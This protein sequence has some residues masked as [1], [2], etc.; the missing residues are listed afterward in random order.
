MIKLLVMVML[1][2][3]CNVFS[4]TKIAVIDSGTDMAHEMII[5]YA[6]VNPGEI[7]NN[8]RDEDRNGYQDDIY[9]WNFAEDNNEIIDYSYLGLLS[10]DIRKF[11][12]IQSKSFDGTITEEDKLWMK[13]MREDA[14]FIN[15]ISTYGNFMHGTHVAGIMVADAPVDVEIMAVKLIPTSIKKPGKRELT[16][17]ED[18]SGIGY[19]VIEQAL[20]TLATQQ[21]NI[22]G[23]IAA[24]IDGH[25]ARVANGSFG[26]GYGQ[27]SMIVAKLYKIILFKDPSDVDL[28]TLTRFFMNKLIEQGRDYFVSVAPD[29][30]FVFA[31]GNDGSNNDMFPTSPTNIDADNVISVAASYKRSRLAPFSNYGVETVDVAAPGVSIMSSV[32]GNEYLVVSGTSQAS[33]H[34]ANVA[35]KVFDINSSLTPKE[36]K[37]IIMGTVDVKE[38]LSGIVKAKGIVNVDRA[39]RAAELSL[40]GTVESSIAEARESV[41]DIA[42]VRSEL[43]IPTSGGQ[44][45]ILPLPSMFALE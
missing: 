14:E 26:T 3:S 5:P 33:P 2:Y 45:Y 9:G 27:A 20:S 22:M 43:E 1:A 44:E 40:R 6:W 23:N 21:V 11:F 41:G 16:P 4:A 10:D 13:K 31:A 35:A 42:D 39:T 34:V 17:D 38:F 32:P 29:T 12:A 7:P 19:K 18:A 30:L 25:G 37:Q 28:D 8:D 24:Y 36:V 15:A